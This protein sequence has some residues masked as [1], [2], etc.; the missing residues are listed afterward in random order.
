MHTEDTL[1]TLAH[2][3]GEG[4]GRRKPKKKSNTQ[5]F[6]LALT[7]SVTTPRQTPALRTLLFHGWNNDHHA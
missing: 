2:D 5:A 4:R 1:V 7:S 6:T 3:A